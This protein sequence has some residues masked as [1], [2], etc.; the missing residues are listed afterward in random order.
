MWFSR[1]R[2]W[3]EEL[4]RP[5]R[6][7]SERE[8]HLSALDGIG[9]ALGL[10]GAG[11]VGQRAE[12]NTTRL[13]RWVPSH[14]RKSETVTVATRVQLT[15]CPTSPLTFAQLQTSLLAKGV[16][17]QVPSAYYPWPTTHQ[18]P[19]SLFIDK[20]ALLDLEIKSYTDKSADVLTESTAQH[21]SV[22]PWV[23]I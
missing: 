20:G 17:S 15:A 4:Q 1:F 12:T 18:F 10:S 13:F 19:A 7:G 5:A 16:S 23:R 11:P 2:S 14:A 9:V 21:S 3:P 8:L 6:V 22:Q